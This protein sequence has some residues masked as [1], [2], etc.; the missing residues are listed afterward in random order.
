MKESI[1]LM[2]FLYL[3]PGSQAH[4]LYLRI[5][6]DRKKSELC[7]GYTIDPWN[8]DEDRQKTKKD[9]KLNGELT[10]IE[11][12]VFQIKRDLTFANKPIS[13]RIIKD[14]YLGKVE[15]YDTIVKYYKSF[16]RKLKS[17]FI[18]LNKASS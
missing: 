1:T 2:F 18:I 15:A 11:N 7:L 9:K 6:V 13:A 3:S 5:V 12:K 14:T 8:W 10:F 17:C 16:I 4:K